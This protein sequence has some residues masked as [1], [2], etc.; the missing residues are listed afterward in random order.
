MSVKA[1]PRRA[2]PKSIGVS[3]LWRHRQTLRVLVQRDLAVKYQ[4]TVMGYLWSLI[5][6]LGMAGIYWFI[7]GVLYGR[8]N[9]DGVSFALYVVSGM[10][11][12]MWASQA[13]NE[14]TSS[15]VS[16]TSLITTMRV[17]REVFPVARV[18]ARFAEFAAG[19]PIILMFAIVFHST[20]TWGWNLLLLPVAIIIQAT[21]LTGISF[22]LASLNVLYRDVQRL[23]RLVM[24]VLFYAA[25][26]VY[27]FARVA[28]SHM[29]HWAKLLYE[30][31]PFVGIIRMQ[32][33]A[34]IPGEIP[35]WRPISYCAGVAVIVLFFGRWLFVRL[36]PA[37]LKEL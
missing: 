1:G 17:P 33:G 13:M 25:P 11:A 30:S 28:N 12:W 2:V 37:V 29:P 20:T 4:K 3:A 26:T 35:G 24:R 34:W 16:Q 22:V 32:H 31:N 8:S 23:M 7:F 27:P 9:I 18:F 36:E 14:S 19:I 10:F 15:L 6:P 5:E 21:L